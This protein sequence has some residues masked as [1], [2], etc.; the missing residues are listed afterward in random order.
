LSEPERVSPALVLV[1]RSSRLRAWAEE[2]FE[3]SGSTVFARLD[4]SVAVY[5]PQAIPVSEQ[6]P[7]WL[8]VASAQ[9]LFV[10][11]DREAR[12]VEG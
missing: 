5:V 12:N 8:S 1:E 9:M 4:G 3:G 6:A 10:F 2:H 11:R 7:P